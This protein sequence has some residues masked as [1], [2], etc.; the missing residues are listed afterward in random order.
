MISYGIELLCRSPKHFAHQLKLPPLPAMRVL[1][2]TITPP[3][4]TRVIDAIRLPHQAEICVTDLLFD[5]DNV[6]AAVIKFPHFVIMPRRAGMPAHDIGPPRRCLPPALPTL[7][8]DDDST[9]TRYGR[10]I[11]SREP[12]MPPSICRGC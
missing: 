4:L 7:S 1:F 10:R 6:A 3:T 12:L 8:L 2:H 9:H 5:Y 11:L